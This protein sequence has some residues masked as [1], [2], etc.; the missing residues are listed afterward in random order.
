MKDTQERWVVEDADASTDA[1]LNEASEWLAYA[2]G[3]AS[4]LAECVRED[5]M[6]R[7]ELSLALGGVAA[8]VAVGTICVQRAHTRVLFDVPKPVEVIDG[9]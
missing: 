6:D 5:E 2:Q 8:L 1:L 7:R 4:L 9:D 3:T